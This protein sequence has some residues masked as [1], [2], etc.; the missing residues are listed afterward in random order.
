MSVPIR[1]HPDPATLLSFAAG[2]LAE[3]LAAVVAAH[4]AMCED[5]RREIARME[6]IGAA[7]L[8]AGPAPA[9]PYARRPD[10]ARGPLAARQRAAIPV[11]RDELLPAP[12]ARLYRLTFGSIP[13]RRLGP[14]V[15]HHRLALSDGAKGDLRLLRIAGGRRMP[16][17]GHGGEELTLVLDGAYIDETGTYRRGDIQDVDGTVEH[18]PIADTKVGC[19]CLIASESPARFK[20]LLARLALP[21]TGM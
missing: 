20:G 10:P 12:I 16:E 4:A 17:H 13:W 21:W 19:V 3:P 5:C 18:T 11:A 8:L 9:A 6:T 2:A 14:G 7:L 1:N 15:W